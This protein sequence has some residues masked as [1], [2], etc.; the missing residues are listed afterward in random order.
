[1]E[2]RET[3]KAG[4]ETPNSRTQKERQTVEGSIDGKKKDGEDPQSDER[5]QG[6]H[7]DSDT[8]TR[9][10]ENVHKRK[11]RDSEEPKERKYENGNAKTL[12]IRGIHTDMEP[13]NGNQENDHTRKRDSRE[14]EES[15][16]NKRVN[17]GEEEPQDE[18]Y[19]FQEGDE[20]IKCG[21]GNDHAVALIEIISI[22]TI[23]GLLIK[24][25]GIFDMNNMTIEST[26]QMI[27]DELNVENISIMI[28]IGGVITQLKALREITNKYILWMK[29][30]VV[31]SYVAMISM[32]AMTVLGKKDDQRILDTFQNHRGGKEQIK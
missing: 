29:Y 25:N 1:M 9:M 6:R 12:A 28:T 31:F 8:K 22:I 18:S 14:D 5:T 16:P 19:L 11:E 24:N 7:L 21:K 26:R 30:P 23:V 32:L 17:P 15:P 27:R 13:G 2:E 20:Y 10:D 3:E 4:K